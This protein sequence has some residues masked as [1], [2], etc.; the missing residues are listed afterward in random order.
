MKLNRLAV[1]GL[2]LLLGIAGCNEKP[3]SELTKQVKRAY[4]I[5]PGI[6]GAVQEKVGSPQEIK[7][8]FEMRYLGETLKVYCLDKDGNFIYDFGNVKVVYNNGT[9]TPY[10]GEHQIH[11]SGVTEQAARATPIVIKEICTRFDE[12]VIAARKNLEKIAN[13][14]AENPTSQK[15]Q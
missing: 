14:P 5:A 2:A 1:G 11:D 3:D 10:I 7:Y 4:E 8:S 12:S 13:I 15:N 9:I 6:P